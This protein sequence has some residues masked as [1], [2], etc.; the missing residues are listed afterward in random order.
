MC[1]IAAWPVSALEHAHLRGLVFDG[2]R[3]QAARANVSPRNAA[4]RRIQHASSAR[5]GQ[6]T[7]AQNVPSAS[8]AKDGA[9]LTDM[10]LTTSRWFTVCAS[11]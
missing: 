4:A 5:A 11:L 9:R 7:S 1:R 8:M 10:P 3:V 2:G 6:R